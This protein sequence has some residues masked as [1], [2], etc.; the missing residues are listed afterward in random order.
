MQ[1]NAVRASPIFRVQRPTAVGLP[2]MRS[3]LRG[4]SY[5]AGLPALLAPGGE[6]YSVDGGHDVTCR[7]QPGH[8]ANK[9]SRGG[10]GSEDPADRLHV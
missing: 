4:F 3:Y 2:D 9:V 5:R 10:A 7:P 6:L 8:E 1:P